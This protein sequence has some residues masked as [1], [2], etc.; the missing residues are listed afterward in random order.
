MDNSFRM[1]HK[2]V[3]VVHMELHM[4]FPFVVHTEVGMVFPSLVDMVFPYVEVD[5]VFP[6]EVRTV[7]GMVFPYMELEDILALLADIP[8]CMVRKLARKARN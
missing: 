8:A 5:M 2:L 1:E 7:E 4:V 3:H 6:F